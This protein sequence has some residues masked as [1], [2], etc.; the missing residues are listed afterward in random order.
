M[1]DGKH[2][3]L[4]SGPLAYH[5]RRGKQALPPFLLPFLSIKR[6]GASLLRNFTSI[7]LPENW[8][9]VLVQS[10]RAAGQ[11]LRALYTLRPEGP[12]TCD[13]SAVER[14]ANLITTIPYFV[15]G[16]QT[17]RERKTSEAKCWGASLIAVGAGATLFH[18]S[19]GKLRHWGR[20]LDYWVIAISTAL[21]QRAVFPAGNAQLTA[22]SLAVTPVQPFFVSATNIGAVEY[23]YCKRASQDAKMKKAFQIHALASGIGGACFFLEDLYPKIPYIH[24]VWHCMSVVSIATLSKLL[25]DTERRAPSGT[26]ARATGSEAGGTC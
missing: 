6:D 17:M 7:Q 11:H 16:L 3:A 8:P 20:K 1:L 4:A 22:L 12:G 2:G 18:A 13:H 23:E 9:E 10:S 24:S 26:A 5:N 14:A 15:M 25:E 21:L 19:T